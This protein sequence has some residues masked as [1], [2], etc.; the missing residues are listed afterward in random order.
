MDFVRRF[1]HRLFSF[2]GIVVTLLLSASPALMGENLR[3]LLAS[4]GIVWP[5]W[6]SDGAVAGILIGGYVLVQAGMAWWDHLAEKA[7]LAKEEQRRLVEQRIERERY[8]L[9]K[10]IADRIPPKEDLRRVGRTLWPEGSESESQS[11]NPTLAFGEPGDP[12]IKPSAP[13]TEEPDPPADG[14]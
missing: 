12:G 1:L 5:V 7:R 10:H 2:W 3:L 11:G 6:A 13:D 14:A 4:W 8:E 9:L